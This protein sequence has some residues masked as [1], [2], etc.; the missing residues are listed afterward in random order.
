MD[1]PRKGTP[2]APVSIDAALNSLKIQGIA[3][4]G[5]FRTRG[6]NVAF[7]VE[8]YIFLESELVNL[9]EQNR[10]NRDSIQELAL[11][12]GAMKARQSQ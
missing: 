8:G 9:F 11:R 10:L 2:F 3:F 1:N 6:K 7:V 12:V 4:R 5:P